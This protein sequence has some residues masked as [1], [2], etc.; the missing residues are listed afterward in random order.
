[1]NDSEILAILNDAVS[2]KRRYP[3]IDS[4]IS[5]E[6]LRDYVFKSHDLISALREYG[7]GLTEP[8]PYTFLIALLTDHYL[9]PLPSAGLM[10]SLEENLSIFEPSLNDNQRQSLVRQLLN[11]YNEKTKDNQ[12]INTL[13]ELGLARYY[14]DAGWQVRLAEPIPS[15]NKNVDRLL[16]M[17]RETRWLDVD[18]SVQEPSDVDGF[19][20]MSPTDLEYRL[21]DKVARKYDDKFQTAINNGWS[22]IR[23]SPSTSRRTM[24][25][26]GLSHCMRW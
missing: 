3:T 22:G 9:L 14:N 26:Q 18:N 10:R 19:G 1:M 8:P 13:S 25:L 20:P 24:K 2:R 12:F 6:A 5:D 23:G 16:N 7:K 4:L 11:P 17:G 21:I 15:T